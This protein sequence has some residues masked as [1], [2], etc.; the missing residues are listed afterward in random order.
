MMFVWILVMIAGVSTVTVIY[1]KENMNSRMKIVAIGG[2]VKLN[3]AM[4][5]IDRESLRISEES[6]YS[7]GTMLQ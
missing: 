3:F 6:G 4:S 7:Q 5:P 2:V 1:K